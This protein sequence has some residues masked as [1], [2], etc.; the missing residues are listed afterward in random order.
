MFCAK[1]VNKQGFYPFGPEWPSVYFHS[2]LKL[3]VSIYVDDFRLAG[4]K[5]NL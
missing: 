3:M 5:E 4:P 2:D 1:N